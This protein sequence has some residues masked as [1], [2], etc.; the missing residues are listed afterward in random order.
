MGKVI[1][2]GYSMDPP[3]EATGAE[4]K[5]MRKHVGFLPSL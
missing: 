3:L 5:G 1:K 2:G 4:R